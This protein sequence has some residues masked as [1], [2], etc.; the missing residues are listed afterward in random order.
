MEMLETAEVGRRMREGVKQQGS[1]SPKSEHLPD[2]E[3][4]LCGKEWLSL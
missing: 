1:G 2:S 4:L 3:H